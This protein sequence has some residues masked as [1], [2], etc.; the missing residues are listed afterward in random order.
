MLSDIGRYVVRR[1][2][3]HRCA[4]NGVTSGRG[5]AMDHRHYGIISIEH[6]NINTII[7]VIIIFHNHNK[8]CDNTNFGFTFIFILMKSVLVLFIL[9]C[10]LYLLNKL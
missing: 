4:R 1:K 3:K 10:T 6:S 7:V 8:S 2:L 9:L 5:L